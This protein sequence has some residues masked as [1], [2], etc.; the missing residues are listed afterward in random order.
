MLRLQKREPNVTFVK[1]PKCGCDTW[2][3]KDGR[4]VCKECGEAFRAGL[5]GNK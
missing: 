4:T 1:C 3:L 5:N 2:V